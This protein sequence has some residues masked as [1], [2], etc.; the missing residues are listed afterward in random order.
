MKPRLRAHF[1]AFL[2]VNI[3]SGRKFFFAI[4]M[5]FFMVPQ[6]EPRKDLDGYRPNNFATTTASRQINNGTHVQFT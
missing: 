4:F 3:A 2:S 1:Y 5:Q 6:H